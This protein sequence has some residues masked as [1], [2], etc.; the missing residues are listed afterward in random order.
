MTDSNPEAQPTEKK[1]TPRGFSLMR[2]IVTVFGIVILGAGAF[3]I[4]E[5][6]NNQGHA[7]IA[8]SGRVT[9]NG[10]PVTIGAVMTQHT[11]DQFEAAIGMFNDKGEFELSSNG[12]PGAAPG[13]HKVII[14]SYGPGMGTTPLVPQQYLK[15]TTTPL[16]ITVTRDP[17][18]NHF[19]LE[20]VGQAPTN[21]RQGGPPGEGG[22]PGGGRRGGAARP[23][24][25]GD[26]S[27]DATS[28]DD[29]KPAEAA[30]AERVTAPTGDKTEAPAGDKPAAETEEKPATENPAVN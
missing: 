11:E 13:V 14:A 15:A 21:N 2:V 20:I 1:Q 6:M 29:S 4:V 27:P 30:A 17:A 12:I 5:L 28:S 7:H 19:E 10:E 24:A 9:W 18:K 23:P 25:E 3:G 16:S 26:S 22:T 8:A